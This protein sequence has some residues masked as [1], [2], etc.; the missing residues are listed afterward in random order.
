M[1][2]T[3]PARKGF[4]GASRM[5]MPAANSPASTCN[6]TTWRRSR[7][8]ICALSDSSAC[9][10]TSRGSGSMS[11]SSRCEPTG[12][13]LGDNVKWI[14]AEPVYS[15]RAAASGAEAGGG[16]AA[17]VA[18]E[19]GV[20]AGGSAAR[21]P[22]SRPEPARARSWRVV[23]LGRRVA[24]GGRERETKPSPTATNTSAKTA[25]LAPERRVQPLAV[26]GPAERL[27][28]LI[29]RPDLPRFG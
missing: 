16:V 24:R 22:V 14:R 5:A 28:F 8:R 9:G 7:E 4:F 13:V 6:G 11:G 3:F 1:R 20:G 15:G 23:G 2:F 29:Q 18:V 27:R 19:E 17:L 25:V 10:G 26:L 12:R 21:P